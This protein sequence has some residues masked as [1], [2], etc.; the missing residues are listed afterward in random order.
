MVFPQKQEFPTLF[1]VMRQ[2]LESRFVACFMTNFRGERDRQTDRDRDR[3]RQRHT[4]TE[5]G[6]GTERKKDRVS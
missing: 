2:F 5:T 4:E 6:R 3:E 1:L